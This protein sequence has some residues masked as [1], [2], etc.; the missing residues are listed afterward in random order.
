MAAGTPPPGFV[1][2]HGDGTLSI[3]RADL[4]DGARALGLFA[5]DGIERAFAA[6]VALDGSSRGPAALIA[7]PGNGP[8]IVVRRLRHGGLLARLLGRAYLGPGRVV[9][10]LSVTSELAR[11]ADGL[12]PEPALALARRLAGPLWE[13]AIGTL[14]VPGVDLFAVLRE[15]A[16]ASA[17]LHAL[18]ACA[19][20]VRAFHDLGARHP[21]LNASN[22]LL[23]P[24]AGRLAARV[25]DLDRARIRERT[26]THRR[27]REIAR[28]WRSLAKRGGSARLEPRERD[29]FL[30]A[31]CA[32]DVALEATL[33]SQ[34]RRERM[35]TAL[36]AWR[37]PRS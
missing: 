35:R 27:A 13:C 8:A 22:L 28:L 25:I 17:R 11:R 19:E 3:V 31:Y 36:H 24:R 1:R 33:R 20:A 26:P 4:A 18:V 6:G 14:R 21:D 9:R 10:E 16:G 32:G 7:W 34:L 15:A 2:E 23:A 30:A 37:Y 12:V 29:A 5:A